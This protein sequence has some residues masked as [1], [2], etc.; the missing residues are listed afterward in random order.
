MYAREDRVFRF[1]EIN[2]CETNGKASFSPVRPMSSG[3]SD[4]VITE[5]TVVAARRSPLVVT[6]ASRQTALCIHRIQF[7]SLIGASARRTRYQLGDRY[8]TTPEGGAGV[9]RTR[10]KQASRRGQLGR[11]RARPALLNLLADADKI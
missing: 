4:D 9:F 1:E 5:N 7:R 2:S 3:R 8:C 10:L 11:E 6:S